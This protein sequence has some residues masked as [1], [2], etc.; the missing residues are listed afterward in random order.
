MLKKHELV[1]PHSCLN[2]ADPNEPIF[3]LRAKDPLA[4]MTIR[5]WAAMADGVH[6]HEK[7]D[8]ALRFAV[9]MDQWHNAPACIAP[10]PPLTIPPMSPTVGYNNPIGPVR[11]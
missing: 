10:L 11:R 1:V 9:E 2:K 5:Y 4:A 3:V 8:E 6:E 7:I